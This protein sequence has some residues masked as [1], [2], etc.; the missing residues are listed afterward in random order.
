MVPFCHLVLNHSDNNTVFYL[1]SCFY[2]VS[3]N[4]ASRGMPVLDFSF[5]IPD[6]LYIPIGVTQ[7]PMTGNN[8]FATIFA[9]SKKKEY[10]LVT[11][12]QWLVNE[13]LRL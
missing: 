11:L 6:Y 7:Q 8:L 3:K 12:A 13:I 1:N 4:R 2:K 9:G 5:D 10:S